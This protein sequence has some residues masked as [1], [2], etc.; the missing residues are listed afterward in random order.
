M[1]LDLNGLHPSNVSTDVYQNLTSDDF[2]HLDPISKKFFYW[3]ILIVSV[4]AIVGNIIAIR[5]II[6]RKTKYLQKSCIVALAI[7]DIF[8]T[9]LFSSTNLD[10]LSGPFIV[11]SLGEFLCYFIPS[12]QIFG[13]TTSSLLLLIIALDR[14]QN[15]VQT[16]SKK[17]WNPKPSTCIIIILIVSLISASLSYPFSRKYF[18][19]TFLVL[20]L[21]VTDK[22]VYEECSFCFADKTLISSYYVTLDAIVFVPMTC[23][24]VWFYVQIAALIWKHRKPITA[25][26]NKPDKDSENSTCSTKTTN[27]AS[28]GVPAVSSSKPKKTKNLQVQRKI[29]TFRVV[30]VLMA[31]F[32]LCRF[33]YWCYTTV[34]F[35]VKCDGRFGWDLNFTLVALNLFNCVLNPLLYTFLNQTVTALKM[36]KEFWWKICCC[37]CSN[38]EF[39]DFAKDADQIQPACG[40]V[41]ARVQVEKGHCEGM[42]K[43]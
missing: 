10:M 16:F 28:A 6:K 23:V 41:K 31:S 29:R 13:T 9:I 22:F 7:S 8:T 1:E 26:F 33:P 11:W 19:E 20:M 39:E 2:H 37:C 12:A 5:S 4:L 34:K 30:L 27:V 40:T 43:Y 17:R 36:I 14:H 35:L 24:F 18:F 25:K 42:Q 3:L 32:V 21:P 15:V 38:D